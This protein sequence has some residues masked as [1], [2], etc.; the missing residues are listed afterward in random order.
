MLSSRL[1]ITGCRRRPQLERRKGLVVARSGGDC[2]S[3]RARIC[4][5]CRACLDDRHGHSMRRRRPRFG[6]STECSSG[7]NASGTRAQAVGL[8]ESAY[9]VPT[10]DGLA[11]RRGCCQRATM[12]YVQPRSS[13]SWSD[14]L[15]GSTR[16]RHR[17][18]NRVRGPHRPDADRPRHVW[19][20]RRDALPHVHMHRATTAVAVAPSPYRSDELTPVTRMMR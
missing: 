2:G 17:H 13:W 14:I 19:H 12:N 7:S 18:R 11:S 8:T 16:G 10:G 15:D 3:R 5:R 4:R 6:S 20:A 9:R 1:G